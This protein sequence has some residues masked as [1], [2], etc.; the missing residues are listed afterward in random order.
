[1]KKGEIKEEVK[2]VFGNLFP[3]L[4]KG[5]FDF[6]KT[7]GDFR[8]WDSFMHMRLISA[9]EDRFGVNLPINEAMDAD[10]PIKFFELVVKNIPKEEKIDKTVVRPIFNNLSEA[11]AYWSERSGDKTFIESLDIK[12]KY[13]YSAFNE[14]VNSTVRFLH[15]QDVRK[16]DVIILCVRNSIEFLAIY[17]A[18]ARLW[19][20]INPIPS[21]VG[22]KELSANVKFIKPKLS[23]IEEKHK[24]G[25]FGKSKIFT[26]RFEGRN[27]FIDDLSKLSGEAVSTDLKSDDPTCLYYSSGTTAKP[28]GIL[29]SHKGLMNRVL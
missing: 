3:E 5:K 4:R 29:F 15:K 14:L 6:K 9:L 24:G 22:V 17:F 2:K 25:D 10:S 12:R 18:S 19:S 21:S 28:K 13:S 27:S 26:I 1:M 16:G 7:Q 11:L 8:D 20:V 23:I